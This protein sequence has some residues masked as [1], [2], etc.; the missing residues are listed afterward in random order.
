M[1]AD[2]TDE[3]P[4]T[5][6]RFVSS[7]IR[8]DESTLTLHT[9]DVSVSRREVHGDTVQVRTVTRQR[10]HLVDENLTHERVEIERVAI[11][12]QVHAVPPVRQEG[13]TTIMSIVEEIVV[14]ERRLI[15]KEEVRIRRHRVTEHHRE[16]VMVREQDAVVTRADGTRP[17]IEGD[18]EAVET[19]PV[20]HHPEKQT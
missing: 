1:I 5:E 17:A 19:K 11:G 4:P 15:L 7:T 10:E 8:P 12:R 20:N 6:A 9:E 2:A 18:R 13:D 16:S 3:A 14:V